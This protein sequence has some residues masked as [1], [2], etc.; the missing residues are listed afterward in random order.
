MT[1]EI[2]LEADADL[3]ALVPDASS[4]A[5]GTRLVLVVRKRFR[6]FGHK[7]PSRAARCAELLIKGWVELGAGEEEGRDAAWGVAP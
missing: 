3:G 4:R 1:E 5:P 2:A 6:L 7:P